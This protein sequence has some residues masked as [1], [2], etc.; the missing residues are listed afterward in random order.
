MSKLECDIILTCGSRDDPKNIFHILEIELKI[1]LESLNDYKIST[2]RLLNFNTCD[3][4]VP[5]IVRSEL[6]TYTQSKRREK[7]EKIVKN[8]NKLSFP[9]KDVIDKYIVELFFDIFKKYNFNI[10]GFSDDHTID[11][12]SYKFCDFNDN[13]AMIVYF[14]SIEQYILNNTTQ[15]N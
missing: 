4:R 9:E 6:I 5:V 13:N 15:R 14:D 2:G 10:I 3:N 12:T 11:Y 7:I 8:I 1:K